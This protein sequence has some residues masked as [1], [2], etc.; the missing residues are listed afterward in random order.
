MDPRFFCNLR[1]RELCMRVQLYR[2]LNGYLWKF[3]LILS[4]RSQGRQFH[5][6]LDDRLADNHRPLYGSL[7]AFPFV[8]F[9]NRMVFELTGKI[10]ELFGIGQKPSRLRLQSANGIGHASFPLSWWGPW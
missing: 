1:N 2:Q 10:G 9:P 8:A 5:P 6:G 7:E 4:W 3:L